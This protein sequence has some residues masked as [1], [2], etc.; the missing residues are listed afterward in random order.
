MGAAGFLGIE[1]PEEYGGLNLGS[2]MA[3]ILA[4]GLGKGNPSITATALAHSGIATAPIRYFGTQEAKQYYLPKIVNGEWVAAYS[5]TE[6]NAGSDANAVEAK[7]TLSA[8][9][10]HFVINGKKKF[11]TNAGFADIFTVFAKV[12]GDE[13]LSAFIVER[14]CP[15]FQSG[16]EE[17]KMGI[18]GSSTAEIILSDVCVPVR[19]LLGERGRGFKIAVTTLNFGRQKLGAACLGGIQVCLKESLEYAKA[20]RQFGVPIIQ[21]GL[22][23]QKL[24]DMA[25]CEFALQAIVY[26]VAGLLEEAAKLSDGKD[27]DKLLKAMSEYSVECA[28]VKIAG[29]EMLDF[30]VDENVQIHGGNGFCEELMP[31]RRYRDSRINRLFEGTNEVNRLLIF[32]MLF[33]KAFKGE[34]PLISASENV[35]NELISSPSVAAAVSPEIDVTQK[36]GNWLTNARKIV[37]LGCGVVYRTLGN[38]LKEDSSQEVVALLSDLVIDIFKLESVLETFAKNPAYKDGFLVRLIFSK[39]LLDIE[40]RMKEVF[41][42]CTSG[43]DLRVLL[44]ALRRV[45]KFDVENHMVLHNQIVDGLLG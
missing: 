3:A 5:L 23:R 34:L 37:L 2:V 25:A 7:A 4:H 8:D 33:R 11:V 29:T 20:R 9:G 17:H 42:C 31:A 32:E 24:A 27:T 19:N 44:A 40:R 14:S 15:G 26:R 39:T 6:E 21:K 35:Y 41:S 45:L 1:V 36:M 10:T 22:I 38:Q 18:N 12:E 13:G 43:D 28:I 16:K 30:V